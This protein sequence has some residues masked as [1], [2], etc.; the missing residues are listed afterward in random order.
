MGILNSLWNFWN[1]SMSNFQMSGCAATGGMV[2]DITFWSR[3]NLSGN[4]PRLCAHRS[5]QNM[6]GLPKLSRV[7]ECVASV[8]TLKGQII[9]D[10][11]HLSPRY[12]AKL[13]DLEEILPHWKW[14]FYAIHS[15]LEKWGRGTAISS[16]SMGW[17]LKQQWRNMQ[18]ELLNI[19]PQNT[20]PWNHGSDF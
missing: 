20:K 1:L 16:S 15:M 9:S 11:G 4:Q 19:E 6:S 7:M 14:C 2:K 8:C 5:H 3:Y 17:A 10:G 13:L 18:E 12:A